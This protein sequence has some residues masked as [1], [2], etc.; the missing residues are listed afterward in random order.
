MG[1]RATELTGYPCVSVYHGFAYDPKSPMRGAMDDYAY[2]YFGWFGFTAELWDPPKAAGIE[3]REWIKWIK[4]HSE[5][6]DLKLMKWN[7]EKLGGKAFHPW[8][9]FDHPQLGKVEIGGWDNK[10]YWTNAPAEY[11]EE[12]C[13]QHS[14]FT[15]AH[16]LMSPHLHIKKA[17]AE[18]QTDGLYKM[19]VVVTNAGFL[20]T[21]T[22][23][24]AMARKVVRPIEARVNLPEGAA[25]VSGKQEQELGHL[26]GRTNKLYGSWFASGDLTDNTHKLE[27]VVNAPEGAQVEVVIKSERAGTVR[28]RLE[29]E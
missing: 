9:E 13:E 7:D 17:T 16:A 27:W 10:N 29:L 3:E 2:E 28:T 5:E 18:K 1:E 14:K 12:M 23:K 6:D 15:L 25:L 24:R 20:P 4:H 19:T 11:L 21:Y 26:E 8:R 22:S